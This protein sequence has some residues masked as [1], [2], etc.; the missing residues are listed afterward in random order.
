MPVITSKSQSI[1]IHDPAA[2]L[3][4]PKEISADDLMPDA[5]QTWQTTQDPKHAAAV[6]NGLRPTFDRAIRKYVPDEDSPLTRADAKHIALQALRNYDPKK[7]NIEGY[8]MPHLQRLQRSTVQHNN[9]IQFPERLLMQRQAM[10]RAE[11][12]LQN[13]LGRGPST[14]ELA[15]Y[16]GINFKQIR[17][18]RSM[19]VPQSEDQAMLIDE[20]GNPT[21]PAVNR[22]PTNAAAE[23]VY[24]SV[25]DPIDQLLIEHGLGLHGQ[26]PKTTNQLAKL[27]N[28][29]ASAV[30]QRA[31][32]LQ[33]QI[34]EMQA[35][36]LF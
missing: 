4:P 16:L 15:D 7:G 32:K 18:L 3:A 21:E 34:D 31:A 8:L 28:M 29:S 36:N 20:E 27:L 9:I 10:T 33:A 6:L 12:E 11:T 35:A 19:H 24:E 25:A 23:L 14:A 17:K 30:S 5:I 1:P 2:K 13:T 22:A 26:K